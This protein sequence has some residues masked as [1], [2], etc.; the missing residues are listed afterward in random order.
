MARTMNRK[1][2]AGSMLEKVSCMSEHIA[3]AKVNDNHAC[4]E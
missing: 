3:K 4:L 2:A 1:N